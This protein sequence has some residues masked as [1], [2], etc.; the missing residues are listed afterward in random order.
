MY[1]VIVTGG[2]QYRVSE[3]D[4][5]KVEKLVAEEGTTVDLDKVLLVANGD[6]IKT[7]AP[8]LEGGR[9]SA[10]VKSHGRAD[11]IKIVKFRRRKH[12]RKSMG[13]RQHY[14]EIQI[15]GIAAG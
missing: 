7:G 15:T 5:I 2:K 9:V 10:L 4:V 3:G 11:K 1:A 12:Y 6:E 14:T 8:Y 13:H